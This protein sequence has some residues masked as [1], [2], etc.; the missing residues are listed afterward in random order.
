[1][2]CKIHPCLEY[3]N[4]LS[5][6][7]EFFL[8]RYYCNLHPELDIHFPA[9]YLYQV[10]SVVSR[11]RNSVWSRVPWRERFHDSARFNDP[12][13]RLT[14]TALSNCKRRRSANSRPIGR[15]LEARV[16]TMDHYVAVAFPCSD[17]AMIR[18]ILSMRRCVN[19]GSIGVRVRGEKCAGVFQA[20]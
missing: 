1:M 13:F 6:P 19:L 12:N 8:S 10:C 5:V 7:S 11:A 9:S 16:W 3:L 17:A 4:I 14:C 15:R 20:W 18:I 2:Q